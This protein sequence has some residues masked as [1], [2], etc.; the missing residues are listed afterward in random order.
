MCPHVILELAWTAGVRQ[1]LFFE[2][3]HSWN[4]NILDL[5]NRH[6]DGEATDHDVPH[7]G[8][9]L[10]HTVAVP[11]TIVQLGLGSAP[12][13]KQQPGC[14]RCHSDIG[15]DNIANEAATHGAPGVTQTLAQSTVAT[16]H[17][18]TVCQVSLKDWLRQRRRHLRPWQPQSWR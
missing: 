3:L 7:G 15:S 16:K 17:Y 6:G 10:V 5:S 2:A 1:M 4:P 14:A 13:I 9:V 11:L 8:H 12:R 18:P